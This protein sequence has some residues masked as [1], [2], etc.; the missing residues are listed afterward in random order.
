MLLT[1]TSFD[2]NKFVILLIRRK[3]IPHPSYRHNSLRIRSICFYFSAE[4]FN[5]RINGTGHNVRFAVRM[6]LFEELFPRKHLIFVIH[7]KIKQVELVV[8]QLQSFTVQ[9][10]FSFPRLHFKPFMGELLAHMARSP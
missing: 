3:F 5:V 9:P 4:L 8:R 6:D 2:N 10:Y 7:H 1:A